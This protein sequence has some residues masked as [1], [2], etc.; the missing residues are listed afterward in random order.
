MQGKTSK[1]KT[2][3]KTSSRTSKKK[4]SYIDC[5]NLDPSLLSDMEQVIDASRSRITV[6]GMVDCPF[7]KINGFFNSQIR[8][9]SS[10][11]DTIRYIPQSACY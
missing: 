6:G 8:T 7:S 3:K 11:K 10:I 5:V 9:V 2:K 4:D 1:K